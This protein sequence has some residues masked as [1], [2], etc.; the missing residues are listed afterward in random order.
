MA[1]RG[2]RRQCGARI[3]VDLALVCLRRIAEGGARIPE[4][5]DAA[6][7][8]GHT[9]SRATL[10][11]LLTDLEPTLGV[12]VRFNRSGAMERWA[13]YVEDWGVLDRRAV[14]RRRSDE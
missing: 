4:L 12:T 3:N 11:R 2:S 1:E 5:L 14:L 6:N 9:A 7:A 8:A 13:Y 10:N